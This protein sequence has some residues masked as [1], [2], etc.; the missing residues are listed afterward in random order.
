[1]NFLLSVEGSGDSERIVMALKND[2]GVVEEV[3]S[4][5]MTQVLAIFNRR[6]VPRIPRTILNRRV[7]RIP[8][9]MLVVSSP[10]PAATLVESSPQPVDSLVE[11]S[12]PAADS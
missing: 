4:I 12:P 1:M 10:Q 6:R 2:D 5:P 3:A 7:L 9:T 11:S 8:R